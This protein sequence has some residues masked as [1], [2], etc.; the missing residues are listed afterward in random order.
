MRLSGLTGHR[1]TYLFQSSPSG[2]AYNYWESGLHK[3]DWMTKELNPASFEKAKRLAGFR[4]LP[5]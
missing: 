5:V 4:E 2:F 1:L 3:G